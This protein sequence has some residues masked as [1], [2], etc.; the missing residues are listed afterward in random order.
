MTLVWLSAGFQFPPPL[1]TG[2]LVPSGTDF[3]VG[4]LVYILGPLGLS[5]KVSCEV[6]SFSCCLNPHRFFQLEVF[7][8]SFL[9][10][11]PW[12]AFSVLLPSYSSQF[13][14]AQMWDRLL[15]QPLSRPPQ[16]SS[17]CFV[18]SPLHPGCWSLSLLLVCINVFL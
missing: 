12:V 18:M 17:R 13:I 4:G 1:P 8:L 2:K 5:N 9:M 6:G 15:R 3:W 16:S 11:E 14:S 10:L 7:R